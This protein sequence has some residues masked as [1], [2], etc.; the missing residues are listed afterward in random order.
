MFYSRYF[1]ICCVS[2]LAI[3]VSS[4][5]IADTA[6]HDFAFQMR[7]VH[8]GFSEGPVDGRIGAGTRKSMAAYALKY[9]LKND[10]ADVERHMLAQAELHRGTMISD[11]DWAAALVGAKDTLNDPFSAKFTKLYYFKSSSGKHVVCG[12]VNAKNLYG[13]YVGDQFFQSLI[14][15]RGEIPLAVGTLDGSSEYCQFGVSMDDFH[16]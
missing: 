8:G 4:P 11:E 14:L 13:A 5:S 15:M 16:K 7:L 2:F 6:Y 3:L 9:G 1:S 12:L 10:R